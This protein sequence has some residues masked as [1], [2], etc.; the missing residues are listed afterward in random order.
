M[1]PLSEIL[2]DLIGIAEEEVVRPAKHYGV[3]VDARFTRVAAEMRHADVLPAEGIRTTRAAMIMI[4]ALD[5]FFA[6][7][8]AD[9]SPWL[10]LA[11]TTLP[12]LR[13]EAW[14]ARWNEQE[15][16]GS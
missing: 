14:R 16:R 15:A 4:T 1:R 11:G 9:S 10:M 5:E 8:R 2:T 7:E 6:S 12:L 3:T 13:T